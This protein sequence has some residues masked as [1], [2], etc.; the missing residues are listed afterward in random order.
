MYIAMAFFALI[1]VLLGVNWMYDNREELR[2]L[3]EVMDYL[4]WHDYVM[5]H[6]YYDEKGMLI[7]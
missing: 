6:F 2:E 3:W 4:F 5:S 1:Y 7:D